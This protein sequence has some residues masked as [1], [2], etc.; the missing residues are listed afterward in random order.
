VPL[1]RLAAVLNLD[2]TNLYGRT[3]DVAALG[4]DQSSLGATFTTAAA[5]EG[6]RV[7]IDS[8]ALIRGSFFRSDH[9]PFAR[10][11]VPALSLESG[12]DYVGRSPKWGEEQQA[13][14]T[15][16]RYHQPQDEI[17]PWFTMD[18][19][20]QQL[21]VILRTALAAANAPAQPTWSQGSEFRAAG[22]ARI[23]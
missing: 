10:A 8:G 12:Q 7:S 19:T 5:A 3:R 6:L 13:E 16:K 20:V 9:F 2:V 23:R 22:E 18:G 15:E 1:K 11:G 4:V 21:H 14:Y 17:L